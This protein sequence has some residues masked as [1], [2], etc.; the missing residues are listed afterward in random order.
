[1]EKYSLP[2]EGMTCASCVARV[3]NAV[4]K[5]EGLEN[6]SVNFATEKVSFDKVDDEVDLNKVAEAVENSGYKLIMNKNGSVDKVKS[7]AADTGEEKDTY[8]TELR[9]DLILSLIF[10]LPVFI[11]SMLGDFDWFRQVWP[12]ET[13]QTNKILLILTTPVMFIPGRRFFRVAWKNLKHFSAEMNTLVAVG[14][15]SAYLYSLAATLFPEA[16]SVSGETPFVYFETAAVIITLILLGRFLEHRAK[17]KSGGAIKK[18]MGLRPKTAL[19][20]DNGNE[21]VVKIEELRTDQ[22][23][24]VKPGEKIPADGVIETGKS[25]VDESM[26]T[27]ES[28]PVEKVKGSQVIGG[29]INKT[30]TFN[31]RITAVDKNS[32]LG[33]IIRMVEDAQGSKAPIQKLA[34]KIAGIFV[35]VVIVI[36]VIT[37]IAWM[38]WAPSAGF[39]SALIHFVAVLIIACP[40]ALGLATPTA[41]MVGTG[42]GATSGILIKNGDSLEIANRINRVVFDKTG[43]ITE[44]TPTVTDI[45]TLNISENELLT[46]LG[47]VEKKSEHPLAGAI[48]EYASKKNITMREVESFNSITG[49]GV[50][51]VIN[52][53]AVVAGN[54]KIMSEYSINI[55]PLANIYERLSDEGKTVIFIGRNGELIGL[56]SIAD[57]VKESS[58]EAIQLLKSMG[59]KIA[60]ITGDNP[61]TA[62]A[63]ADKAEIDDYTAEVLPDEKADQVK[64]YQDKGEIVAMV[65]DG[66]NDAPALAQ[67]DVGIAMGS[68]TDVAMETG[69]ITLVKGN[70]TGVPDAINLSHKTI[71]TIKQN[72]FWA[73][74]YNTVGIPLAALGLLNPMIAALAMSFSSVSVVTNSLRLKRI[75][76]KS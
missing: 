13:M 22:I 36:A 10:T 7:E 23:V 4:R 25:T 44:G 3:E 50:T 65:G 35:P 27:G 75:K 15:G 37:F 43:T 6:V 47:S 56:V 19:V 49:M 29:T 74:I 66:I 58:L 45:E 69:D 30:G 24:I 32:V 48:V 20:L 46:L 59:I 54:A 18:L 60:M 31:F 33:Q 62:K 28:I 61:K 17:K 9:K 11:I 73:F 67:A 26:I 53:D 8:Y 38:L 2:V 40:C 34:D 5:I 68:G 72:L 52:G 39:N 64:K 14:T 21:V 41:I 51:G 70:L 42:I 63:I 55:D 71:V 57:P 76:L 16:I 1:M 12:L